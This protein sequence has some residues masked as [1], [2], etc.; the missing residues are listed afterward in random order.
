M[1]KSLVVSKNILNFAEDLRNIIN[2][3]F[4]TMILNKQKGE[5][6]YLDRIDA[7]NNY[8]EE[9]RKYDVLTSEQELEYII[10][11]QKNGDVNARDMLVKANQ[12][13]VFAAAKS[14]TTNTNDIM[15]L[16]S[17]GN[18]GLLDAIDRY[19]INSGYRL[20]S[21]AQAYIHRNM[22]VYFNKNQLIYR[23][24]DAKL[25]TIMR[26][27]R[28]LFVAKNERTPTIDELREVVHKK[29]GKNIRH[30]EAYMPFVHMSLSDSYSTNGKKDSTFEDS[31]EFVDL[32]ASHNDVEDT[33]EKEHIKI[34]ILAALNEL[35]ERD[36]KVV[37]MLFGIGYERE[38]TEDEVA[39]EMK[40]SKMR[41]AQIKR[42]MIKQMKYS[43][44]LVAV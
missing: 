28:D 6:F 43:K 14:M 42:K 33:I 7:L 35:P 38:Y 16:I 5:M 19:D 34:N 25:G 21:Y 31:S 17:E 1:Q 36:A 44:Y 39:F 3:H 24:Y 13:F 8:L 4:Y 26:R 12:R 11:Y 10:A 2:K 40:L 32:T 29:Y 41:I 23:A 18:M 27:E 15:D 22:I 37:K 20:L 9:V 30:D